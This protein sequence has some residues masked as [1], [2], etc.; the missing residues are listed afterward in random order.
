MKKILIIIS[1]ALLMGA[2][3]CKTN[4][5]NYRDAYMKAKEK[6]TE[7]GDSLTTA[8]LRQSDQPRMMKIGTDSV[9]VR[10]FAITRTVDAGSAEGIKKYCIVTGKF[11]QIFNATSMSKRLA[12]S[13][14]PEACVIHDR[15][16]YY[17]VIACATD[18]ATE[19]APLL[20][21]VAQ[22]KSIVLQ[23]P[24][25]YVLRPAHLVR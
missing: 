15:Q 5:A 16:N 20:Q 25:P 19:V 22:D 8:M 14:Y 3:A 1:V 4:E 17:Y 12:E 13:G 7:T 24:F 6:Q 2:Y 10:T 23:P 21:R 18:V 9:P 11:R